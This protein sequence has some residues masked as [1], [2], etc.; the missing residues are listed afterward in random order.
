SQR[1][2]Q[3]CRWG[4]RRGLPLGGAAVMRMR[5]LAPL[6]ADAGA[7]AARAASG[8]ETR[9]DTREPPP[10]P[11]AVPGADAA[12]RDVSGILQDDLPLAVDT[13][14]QAA[15]EIETAEAL[16]TP[17][18]ASRA[19]GPSARLDQTARRL[20]DA[21]WRCPLGADAAECLAAVMSPVLPELQ[22]VVTLVGGVDARSLRESGAAAVLLSAATL[23]LRMSALY[24][25]LASCLGAPVALIV[26]EIGIAIVRCLK[27]CVR[28]VVA[29]L[30]GAAE[31]G[32]RGGG[33]QAAQ[34][35]EAASEADQCSNAE[36]FS[37]AADAMHGLHE[38]LSRH[39]LGDDQLHQLI[40]MAVGVFF[41]QEPCFRLC[42]E[43]E[44]LLCTIFGRREDLRSSVVSELLQ[45]VPKL[46]SGRRARRFQLP[47]SDDSPDSG[48]SVWTHLLLR[49][50]QCTCLPLREPLGATTEPDLAVVLGRRSAAQMAIVQLTSGLIHRLLLTRS[51]D[52]EVRAVLDELV[53]ELLLVAYKPPWP[54]APA[55]LRTLTQQLIG[56]VQ[57]EKKKVSTDALAREYALKL[58]SKVLT[59]LWHHHVE[60]EKAC[61]R[62]P[63]WTTPPEQVPRDERLMQHIALRVSMED[64][65]EMPWTAA[66]KAV[67]AWDAELLLSTT[68]EDQSGLC[69]FTDDIVFRYLVMAHLEDE[70]SVPARCPPVERGGSVSLSA[71]VLPAGHPI[72]AWSFLVC[73]WAEASARAHRQRSAELGDDPRKAGKAKSKVGQ[74]S[75]LER[76]LACGWVSRTL[77]SGE[78]SSWRSA[79]GRRVLMPFAVYKAY[80]QLR[81][82]EFEGLR[83]AAL[84][85][86]VVQ[87]NGPAAS[88]RKS[89][90]RALSDVIDIDGAVL[91]MKPVEETIDMRL[92]D[93]SAWVRQVSLDVLGRT[94]EAG[95]EP[96]VQEGAAPPVLR[97][98]DSRTASVSAMLL[99]FHKTVR[100][101][102][103]DTSVLVRRQASKILSAFV[104]N[105]PGHPDVIEVALDLLR[106]CSD[107][108][109]LRNLVLGTFEL[110]WF[111]E[112]EPTRGAALQLARVVDASRGAESGRGDVLGELLRRFRKNIGA[113]KASK[114]YEFA[115]RRWTTLLLN[116]FVHTHGGPADGQQDRPKK[117]LRIKTTSSDGKLGEA[118]ERWVQRRSL[119]STLEAG[120]LC[121]SSSATGCS[122][123]LPERPAL[124]PNRLDDPSRSR[125]GLPQERV[126]TPSVC[127]VC[128]CTCQYSDD[129]L[130]R[131]R[132]CCSS[133]RSWPVIRLRGT[134]FHQVAHAGCAFG[135]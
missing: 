102:V 129:G 25:A 123:A 91:S 120:I 13:F 96:A 59:R 12:A 5:R 27:H 6:H 118:E 60:A 47:V 72:H 109:A 80:R 32:R 117:K 76:F 4:R 130:S 121:F 45:M 57:P 61:I 84:D 51:R 74:D 87:A 82:A 132:I 2:P 49:L 71:C 58:M 48:L 92:R 65:R 28:E 67:R 106:R 100:G 97:G 3:G 119:L 69:S 38:F 93:E 50:T 126:W 122:T 54:G 37:A 63:A 103:H 39:S 77:L 46:P 90:V 14:L 15:S 133:G 20:R 34:R 88:M 55:L 53:D 43:A 52:D 99:R 7:Q 33:A 95:M 113:R 111:M 124:G 8:T 16:A 78:G 112:E 86:I 108:E 17:A 135:L 11:G 62:L 40:H 30:F 70:R 75:A 73:D 41:F 101:R 134:N 9:T 128:P 56:I 64:G 26:E 127:L 98:E 89:A 107:S 18:A 29:P 44:E 110:L 116:E 114:G 1:E 105:H 31:G 81:D 21:S 131:A 104:L 125:G 24:C 36:L 42:A 35:A 79:G 22:R 83:K 23:G 19:L 68:D 115:I 10:A 94:L 85:C 66:A